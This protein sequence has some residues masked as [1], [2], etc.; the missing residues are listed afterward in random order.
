MRLNNPDTT[1]CYVEFYGL[2]PNDIPEQPYELFF[3]RWVS[4]YSN[5]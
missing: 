4:Y 1:L 2:N 3:G 5:D